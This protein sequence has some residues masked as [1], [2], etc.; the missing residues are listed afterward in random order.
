MAS[1]GIPVHVIQAIMGHT[2]SVTTMVVY[3]HIL[4]ASYQ[5]LTERMNAAYSR[6]TDD[7]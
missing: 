5:E 6:V 7:L 4:P 2:T 1:E 3:T